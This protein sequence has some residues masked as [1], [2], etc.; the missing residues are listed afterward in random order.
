MSS[1]HP[2]S[3]WAGTS[4]VGGLSTAWHSQGHREEG[5]AVVLHCRAGWTKLCLSPT[6]LHMSKVSRHQRQPKGTLP[7]GNNGAGRSSGCWLAV[8]SS[9]GTHTQPCGCM[10]AI[11]SHPAWGPCCPG[12]PSLRTG[13]AEQLCCLAAPERCSSQ[14][15]P[16]APGCLEGY[17]LAPF[18]ISR[19]PLVLS[20][21]TAIS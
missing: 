18:N 2:V 8:I 21:H 12:P 19:G 5:R 4:G 6:P 7:W 14:R 15:V 16:P 10:L 9:L 3:S 11:M 1:V 17:T 20:A 13:R